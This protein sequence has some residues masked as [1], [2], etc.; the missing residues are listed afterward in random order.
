MYY[1]HRSHKE[2]NGHTVTPKDFY[3]DQRTGFVPPQMP[4][5]RLS[6]EWET[7]EVTLDL[8][9]SLKLKVT[10]QAL[11]LDAQQKIVEEEKARAWRKTVEKVRMVVPFN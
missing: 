11:L 3:V 10:E 8:A 4:L 2:I 5:R 1:P 7:W 9:K 6:T